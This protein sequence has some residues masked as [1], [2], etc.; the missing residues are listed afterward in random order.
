M[1]V[2]EQFKLD[3]KK[4]VVLI[5]E[6][7]RDKV[8]YQNFGEY[9]KKIDKKMANEFTKKI[10]KT[11]MKKNNNKIHKKVKIVKVNNLDRKP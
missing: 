11:E 3:L 1:K 9:E 7:L 8:D 2:L 10:D 5:D 6:Q 4:T